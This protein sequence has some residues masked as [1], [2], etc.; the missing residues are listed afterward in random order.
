MDASGNNHSHPVSRVVTKIY[1]SSQYKSESI[2]NLIL[3]GNTAPFI[4]FYFVNLARNENMMHDPS[5]IGY[6][7][8]FLVLDHAV[9]LSNIRI[10]ILLS[11]FTLTT[12]NQDAVVSAVEFLG[13][14][15]SISY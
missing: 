6:P 3:L 5:S 8:V 11:N 9:K 14:Y 7:L 10:N 13:Q 15:I 2:T 12:N 1:L 4:F